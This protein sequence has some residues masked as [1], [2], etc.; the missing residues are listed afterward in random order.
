MRQNMGIKNF[1]YENWLFC[2]IA[3]QPVLDV[4]AYWNQ[5]SVATAAGY[6]RLAIMLALPLYLLLTLKKKK[7]FVI[8]MLSIGL[9]CALHVLNGFRTG[10]IS[11]FFD[12]AYLAKIAQMPVLAVCFIFLIRDEGTKRQAV[13]GVLAAAAI[14]FA[15]I[16]LALATGTWNSTYGGGIGLSGW[17]IDDNRCANS[18]LLVTMAVFSVGFAAQSGKRWVNVLLPAVVTAMLIA[19]G[20]KACYAGLFAVLLGYG[21]FALLRRPICGERVKKL[22]VLALALL[23]LIS[24]AVYPVS[25]RARVDAAQAASASRNQDELD[26]RLTALGYDVGAMSL[27]EKLNDPVLREIFEEYYYKMIGYVIPDMFERFGMEKVLVKYNMSTSAQR[28]GDVRVMK[29]SYA[30]LIWDEQDFMTKLVGFEI[31]D[32]CGDG[33]YD[34]ENDWPALFYYCGYLGFGL[35]ALFILYFFF[36]IIKRLI[37]DFKGSFTTENFMLLLCLILQLGLAQFSGAILRRPNVS[38][39]LSLVLALIYYKTAVLPLRGE[40]AAGEG[41]A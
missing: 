2:L 41:A 17:V 28:L 23:A 6:I 38:V 14:M 30:S 19:N 31:T 16:I 20:T 9:F 5:N 25:P 32:A 40:K 8:S 15:A 21:V 7:G 18:I 10:Y 34:M 12:L 29:T 24:A 3:A 13:N 27:E 4:I 36:L 22:F 1:F 33:R 39:Y 26:E 11:L 37:I 35:Y